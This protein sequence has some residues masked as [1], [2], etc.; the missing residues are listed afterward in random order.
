MGIGAPGLIAVVVVGVIVLV[1][2]LHISF[3]ILL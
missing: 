3:V 2:T 1:V